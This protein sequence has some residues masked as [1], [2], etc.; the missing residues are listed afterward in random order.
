MESSMLKA[1]FG[2]GAQA[3]VLNFLFAEKCDETPM[4]AR[5]LARA[6]GVPAGSIY[7]T[8]AQLVEKQLVEKLD[9]PRGSEYRAPVGDPRLVGLF[10]VLRQESVIVQQ[11]RQ[12]FKS[13][14]GVEFAGV[15]GSFAR[16]T[17]CAQSD[18]DVLVLDT[19]KSDRLLIIAACQRASEKC[20]RPVNPQF[21]GFEEFERLVVKERDPIAVA[22][23]AGSTI[24]IKG[25]LHE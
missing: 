25:K 5:A 15:F 6:A 14:R 11:L 21:Y 12:A 16:G 18:V 2:S 3:K 24:H 7:L 1:L 17:T 8:L 4:H 19:E 20:G 23:A 9:A 22:I 10:Q 13:Q